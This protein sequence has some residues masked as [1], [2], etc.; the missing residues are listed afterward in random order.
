MALTMGAVLTGCTN[1]SYPGLEYEPVMARSLVNNESGRGT[2]MEL[3][4]TLS[5]SKN[6][7][8]FAS[9]ISR[10][11]GAFDASDLNTNAARLNNSL[12]YIFAFRDRA[13]IQGP[14]MKNPSFIERSTNNNEDCLVDGNDYYFGMPAK[15]NIEDLMLNMKRHDLRR[16]T[17]LYYGT[18]HQDTGYNFY[19]YYVDDLDASQMVSYRDE[20]GVYYDVTLDG[21]R[22]IMTGH[23]LKL[24]KETLESNYPNINKSLTLSQ[25]DH[26]LNNGNYS[27]YSAALGVNPII[28][29]QHLL[30]R[31]E[32]WAYPADPSANLIE[33]TNVEIEARYSGR[34]YVVRGDVNQLNFDWLPNRQFLQL[35]ERDAADVD[36]VKPVRDLT[37]SNYK[38]QWQTGMDSDKWLNN[39]AGATH[40]GCDMLLPPDT[41][42][43]LKLQYRQLEPGTGLYRYVSAEYSLKAPE[44]ESSR[45]PETGD[46]TYLSG[47]IYTVNIGVYGGRIP[48]VG[49]SMVDPWQ[50]GGEIVI[51]SDPSED[52]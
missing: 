7:F 17:T 21:T 28:Q 47:N 12:F 10:G 50:D 8:S 2:G 36:K 4:V 11:T 24:T 33:F 31:L 18:R 34:L 44:L 14:Q 41:E 5:V 37:P 42:Y 49:I 46:F 43:R 16:D 39:K 27:A 1:E 52:D 15:I 19:A 48:E 35:K 29:M 23:S 30:T 6:S 45:D 20:T 26:I 32:F 51:P 38:V 40:I 3:P 9:V 22:D 25:R 13:D